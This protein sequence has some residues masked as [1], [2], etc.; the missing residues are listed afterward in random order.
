MQ[1]NTSIIMLTAIIALTGCAT[2][3]YKP[4]VDPYNDP[5]AA[6]INQDLLECKELAKQAAGNSTA[7][8]TAT[9]AAIGGLVGAAAGAAIGAAAGNPGT[10]AAIGAAAGGFGGG[11][12]QGFSTEERFKN[13]YDNCMG[14]RGHNVIR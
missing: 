8:E 2:L 7:T 5:N 1:L 13:A 14:G 11:A 9:G 3:S 4:T 12:K 10:G 6:R